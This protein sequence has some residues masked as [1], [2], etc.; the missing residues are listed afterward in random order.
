MLV[1]QGFVPQ[2]RVFAGVKFVHALRLDG[3]FAPLARLERDAVAA[4]RF[5]VR[6][7]KRVRAVMLGAAFKPPQH[8]SS[9]S[10]QFWSRLAQRRLHRGTF[11]CGEEEFN[12]NSA[13]SDLSTL[14]LD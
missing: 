5:V 9:T 4:S 12:S 6:P 8:N 13:C 10:R 3:N 11:S 2:V 14:R 1:S 7:H